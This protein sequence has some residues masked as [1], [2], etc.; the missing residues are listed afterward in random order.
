MSL[1]FEYFSLL[2]FCL[3]H[4]TAEVPKVRFVLSKISSYGRNF[5]C[6]GNEA[7]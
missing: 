2:K 4:E 7:A 1:E 5:S 3:P 6:V